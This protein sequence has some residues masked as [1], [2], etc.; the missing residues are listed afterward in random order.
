MK[1]NIFIA[2]L[3]ILLLYG[4]EDKEPYGREFP[5]IK[6]LDVIDID[7]SGATFQGALVKEGSTTTSSYGFVWDIKNPN[8]NYANK[9]I[10]GK[11]IDSLTFN[12]RID[13]TI[14]N[15]LIYN[16]R[17]F[18]T[19]D[20]KTLYGNVI[21]FGSKGCT[22]SGWSFELTNINMPGCNGPFG[23]SNDELGYIIFEN[24]QVYLYNPI[25]KEILKSSDF[26]LR[27]SSN[28]LYTSFGIGND[29][30][31][32]CDQDNHLYKL[33]NGK[34]TQHSNR[35]FHYSYI[36]NCY[37]FAAS[38]D[39]IYL[40]NPYQSYMY[41]LKLDLWE[42]KADLNKEKWGYYVGGIDI[43]NKAYVLTSNKNV[44]EYDIESDSWIEKTKYPGNLYDKIISFSYNNKL[45]FGL[46]H[47][48]H[49]AETNWFDR[50]LWIY[51]PDLDIWSCTQEF[52]IELR[53]GNL[54]FFFLKEKLYLG[55]QG[56]YNC[57]CDNR[58]SSSYS[59]YCIWKFDPSIVL[60]YSAGNN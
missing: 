12:V 31:F 54:F 9:V 22:K 21:Q 16:V 53:N 58:S 30:Y 1:Y 26:P 56:F 60:K 5:I 7:E 4:C 17:V 18:A 38:S 34:W 3:I 49:S 32:L 28:T 46:S 52:P 23:S 59:G 19:Y 8:I 35:A 55:I 20:E 33:H 51:D 2:L 27:V 42:K 13:S 37:G 41:D 50:N 11:N 40:L 47:H 36:G 39:K 48:D 10:L 45:F 15:D 44:L 25:E 29:Q 14:I 24:S 57:A 43:K 6:T